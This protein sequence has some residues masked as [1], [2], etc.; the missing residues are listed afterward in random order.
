MPEVTLPEDIYREIA[1]R[2]KETEFESIDSYVTYVLEEILRELE[3]ETTVKPEEEE[4]KDERV[5]DRLR[6]LGYV[7]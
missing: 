6:D 7:D 4:A 3:S 5:K 2:V 1:R